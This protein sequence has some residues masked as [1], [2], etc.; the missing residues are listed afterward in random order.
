MRTPCARVYDTISLSAACPIGARGR[1]GARRVQPATV[2]RVEDGK[3]ARARQPVQN[4][5]LHGRT[6]GDRCL[7]VDGEVR[8]ESGQPTDQPRDARHARRAA[9]EDDARD[10]HARREALQLRVARRPP[11]RHPL[12]P[13]RD[14][15]ART[16]RLRLAS[17]PGE[18]GGRVDAVGAVRHVVAE[19]ERDARVAR[20]LDDWRYEPLDE[21]FRQSFHLATAERNSQVGTRARAAARA[22]EA[23]DLNLDGGSLAQRVARLLRRAHEAVT[24]GRVGDEARVGN[25]RVRQV[26]GD[27]LVKVVPA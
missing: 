11:A 17:E 19:R 20:H 15:R 7:R 4:C 6:L 21:A 9:D 8:L 16:V 2:V 12:P 27:R 3:A 5:R 23:D 18:G 10:G 14:R 25:E 26:R 22:G 1:R 13:P 24:R